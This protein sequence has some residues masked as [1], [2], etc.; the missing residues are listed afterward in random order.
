MDSD[1]QAYL[2][3]TVY[4][5]YDNQEVVDFAERVC[6]SGGSPTEKAIKLYYAVRDE[7][8]YDP[9]DVT[10]TDAGMQASSTIRK[11]SGFCITKAVVL[12]ALGRQQGIPTRLGFADVQNHLSTA[13]LRARMGS[14]IFR[15]HGYT[16]FFLNQ[17]WVK[18]TPAF[19]LALCQRFHVKPLEFNG[20]EDSIFHEFNTL[21]QM[22]MQYVRDHGVY[23]DLPFTEIL[24]TFRQYYPAMFAE[25]TSSGADDFDTEAAAEQHQPR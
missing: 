5:D 7:I 19:N 20:Q 8:R 10:F 13:R 3:A 23:A 9:Y 17:R 21:G 18:A 22:H 11:R 6:A 4:L 25:T 1:L 15:Y 2:Q 14:D 12:A 16:E 24:A